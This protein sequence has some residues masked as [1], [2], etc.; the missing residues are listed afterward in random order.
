MSN[1]IKFTPK[2]G[3]IELGIRQFSKEIYSFYVKDN[4]IGIS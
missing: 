3:K 2:Q 1:A 4:G